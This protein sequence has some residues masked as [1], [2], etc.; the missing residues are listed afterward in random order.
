[1]KLINEWRQWWRMWSVQFAA[2]AALIVGWIIA[3]PNE[4]KNLVDQVPDSWRPVLVAGVS[5]L[6]FA[7]PTLLRLLDQAKRK[8]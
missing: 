1:M 6:T 2:I 3:N 5:F 8:P 4:V 7:G